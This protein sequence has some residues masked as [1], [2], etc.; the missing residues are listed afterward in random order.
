MKKS[1]LLSLTLLL[2]FHLS[3][4]QTSIQGKLRLSNQFAHKLYILKFNHIDPQPPVVY[5]SIHIEP[6]GTF[7]YQFS[8]VSPQDLLFKIFL[9]MKEGNPFH[10]F[11]TVN[12]NY[13]YIT[14][15][16][17]EKINVSA[18]ADSLFYSLE[19]KE[20]K[21]NRQLQAFK[22]LQKKFFVLEKAMIDSIKHDPSRETQFKQKLL[23][24][25]MREVE[26]IKPKY[27][28]ILDST[29][30]VSMIL[31]GLSQL[32]DANFGSLDS[33]TAAKY[34]E[35]VHDKDFMIVK[36]IQNLTS[37][38]VS[39]RLGTVLPN[40]SLST[41]S[42]KK[43]SLYDLK[44]KYILIDFWASWCSPCRH[45]NKNELPQLF[46]KY[47]AEVELI[48][49]SVDEDLRKWKNAVEKDNTSWKQ[50]I[51]KSYTLKKMLE[52]YAVPVYVLLDQNHKI[53]FES[54]SVYLVDEYLKK[55][56]K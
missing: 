44:G 17:S 16:G 43:N 22:E 23:P 40:V 50:Y 55:N 18:D 15:E 48:G 27:V 7:T 42:G 21:I 8:T 46:L 31:F 12:K 24:V 25:W 20:G 5:D 2:L 13:F 54:M 29:R 35:K 49:V 9:P 53:I 4:A 28:S 56:L 19:I 38:Q 32:Y 51:D 45:A 11:G 3:L 10:T 1:A 39:K 26:R 6:D 14:T 36:T 37:K 41:V 52:A 34:L 47:K 33:T 30:Q